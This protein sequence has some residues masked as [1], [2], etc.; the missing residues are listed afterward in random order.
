MSAFFEDRVDTAFEDPRLTLFR[1]GAILLC[2]LAVVLDGYDTAAVGFAAPTIA[3]SWGLPAA[4]FTPAFVATS[5]WAVLGF[6]TAGPLSAR[7]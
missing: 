3:R 5:V 4:S 6:L 2:F 1:V 7:L